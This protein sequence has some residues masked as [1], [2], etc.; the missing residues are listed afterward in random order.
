MQELIAPREAGFLNKAWVV[1]GTKKGMAG[2]LDEIKRVDKEVLENADLLST[3]PV[4]NKMS[5]TAGRRTTR[6]E[7]E[8][9]D[10]LGIF[11]VNMPLLYGEGDKAFIRL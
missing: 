11:F 5:W 10:L 2:I 4:G 9:Y 8:A 3:I 7:D 6:V 1:I